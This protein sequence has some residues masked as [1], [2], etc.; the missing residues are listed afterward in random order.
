VRKTSTRLADGRE[1]IYFDE[2]DSP[3]RETVDQRAP[4]TRPAASELRFDPILSEWV[5]VAS[6]RQERTL[7]PDPDHCP[8]CPSTP[9]RATEIPAYDY[10]VVAFENRF[11]AFAARLDGLGR[12]DHATA[13][14]PESDERL[15]PKHPGVGRCEVVCFT[16]EHASSFSALSESRVRTVVAAWI[17]RSEALA[18][19]EGVEEVFCFENRGREIGVTLTHPHGQIYGYP[20]VTPRTQR[21]L[22]SARRYRASGGGDLFADMLAAEQT[23]EVRIVADTR[24]W[25]AFVPSAA[26]WPFEVHLYPTR[27]V[28]DLAALS[29]EERQELAGIYV[30]V[31][32]RFESLD[33]GPMPYIAAWHQAPVRTGRDLAYLHLE[34]FTVWRAPG[35]LKYL[36]A[37]ESA[38]GAFINDVS[39]E[40]AARRLRGD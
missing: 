4:S 14:A 32:S 33:A 19:M 35:R 28:P 26:R 1:L 38:M 18:A 3:I 30:E 25:T 22:Q 34:L 31:L 11:P 10:D 37:S 39:P 9:E 21:M 36:A 20:F 5:T 23:A 2:D 29:A 24:H 12:G 40:E 15:F 8:L 17:D 13:A 16:S 27:Q 6:Q 7:L